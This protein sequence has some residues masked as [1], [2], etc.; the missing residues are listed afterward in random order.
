MGIRFLALF[1]LVLAAPLWAH[2][3]TASEG[4]AADAASDYWHSWPSLFAA[5]E[6]YSQCDDGAIVEGFSD[7]IVHLLAS[8]WS[9]LGQAQ[10]FI[11][12]RPAFRAFIIR[13]ID[14]TTDTDE[15]LSVQ[16]SATHHCPASASSLCKQIAAA[17][18]SAIAESYR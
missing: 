17:A 3:C 10:R 4:A 16:R 11:S 9:T 5:Y 7:D 14:A 1:L 18:K 6:R 13:H 2:E 12:L 15:L 8:R